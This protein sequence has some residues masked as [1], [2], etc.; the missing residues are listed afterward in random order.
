MV[1]LSMQQ[2][3]SEKE[4]DQSREKQRRLSAFLRNNIDHRSTVADSMMVSR[5]PSLRSDQDPR[6]SD[7]CSQIGAT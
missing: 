7:R 5:R 3:K 2:L 4:R 6:D 1:E